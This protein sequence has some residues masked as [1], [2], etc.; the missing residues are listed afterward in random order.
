[1]KLAELYREAKESSKGFDI[2]ESNKYKKSFKKRKIGENQKVK[3][4]LKKLFAYFKKGELPPHTPPFENHKMASNSHF[5]NLYDVHV[6][7]NKTI[8]LYRLDGN[9]VELID[10]GTHTQLGVM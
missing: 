1:M 7:G 2:K 6:N 9:V 8:L 4:N 3:S 5:K 10:I